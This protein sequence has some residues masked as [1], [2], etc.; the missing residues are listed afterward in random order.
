MTRQTRSR[1][2]IIDFLCIAHLFI[3]ST[4][5]YCIRFSCVRFSKT[6]TAPRSVIEHRTHT[7]RLVVILVLVPALNFAFTPSHHHISLDP[8][9]THA[10]AQAPHQHEYIRFHFVS[11]FVSFFYRSDVFC[12]FPPRHTP[13]TRLGRRT[14]KRRYRNIDFRD[15]RLLIHRVL[16]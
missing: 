10:A 3:C 5:L 9:H 13:H 1:I 7:P 6:V 11:P 4:S 8:R 12:R 2:L 15:Y 16:P 14:R